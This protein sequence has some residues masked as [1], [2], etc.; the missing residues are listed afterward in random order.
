M[1]E[2]GLNG[3]KRLLMAGYNWLGWMWLEMPDV[4]KYGLKQLEWIE[5]AEN[6]KNGRKQRKSLDMTRNGRKWIE[7]LEM[8]ENSQKRPEWLNMAVNI[9]NS[10]KLLK[11]IGN[12]G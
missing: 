3:R 2:H 8:A 7:L 5:T 1:A 11:I 6:Y 12:G 10:C 4:A 9:L